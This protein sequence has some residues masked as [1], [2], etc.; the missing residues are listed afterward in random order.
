LKRVLS[1]IG[2]VILAAVAARYVD[3]YVGTGNTRR[4][5]SMLITDLGRLVDLVLD[6]GRTLI[7]QARS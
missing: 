7:G 4:L 3:K 6:L 2:L 5:A 1:A